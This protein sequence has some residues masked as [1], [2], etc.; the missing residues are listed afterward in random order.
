METTNNRIMDCVQ[1]F[2]H[3]TTPARLAALQY[4]LIRQARLH[5]WKGFFFD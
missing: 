1:H 2:A 4:K 5:N 3:S